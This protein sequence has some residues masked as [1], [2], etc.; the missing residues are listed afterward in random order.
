MAGIPAQAQR[1]RFSGMAGSEAW[2][3]GKYRRF[4][5]RQRMPHDWPRMSAVMAEIDAR[6]AGPKH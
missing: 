3:I 2:T 1:G 4:D 6:D 5:R